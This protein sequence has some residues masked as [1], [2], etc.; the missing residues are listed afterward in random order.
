MF[1]CLQ[2]GAAD[3]HNATRHIFDN[4][5][6]IQGLLKHR[7][8]VLLQKTKA[9]YDILKGGTCI[10]LTAFGQEVKNIRFIYP[11]VEYILEI[12]RYFTVHTLSAYR[13]E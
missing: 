1:Q 8:Q 7:L 2:G 13:P 12:H 3:L 6:F 10:C 4:G 5:F 11:L 9:G